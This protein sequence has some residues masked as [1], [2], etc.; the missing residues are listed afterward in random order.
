[1]TR[2]KN[3]LSKGN[4]K[5]KKLF[6]KIE[7]RAYSKVWCDNVIYLHKFYDVH[8]WAWNLTGKGF[9]NENSLTSLH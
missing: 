4:F 5:D 1:M 8:S 9:F 6:L 7:I 2:S 3:K